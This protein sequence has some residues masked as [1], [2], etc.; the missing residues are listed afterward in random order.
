MTIVAP[1]SSFASI[2]SSSTRK[3]LSIK[4]YFLLHWLHSLSSRLFSCILRQNIVSVCS[5]FGYIS[6]SRQISKSLKMV[7]GTFRT[8]RIIDYR[9]C[10]GL[11]I[12]T[13]RC[14]DRNLSGLFYYLVIWT[15]L[16]SKQKKHATYVFNIQNRIASSFNFVFSA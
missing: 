4:T 16:W 9:K 1:R 10:L 5:M 13:K 6:A 14:D 15:S 12:N 11:L 2:L 7:Q 8:R 3:R